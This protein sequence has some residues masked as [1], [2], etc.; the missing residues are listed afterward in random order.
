MA[1]C[2]HEESRLIS[3]EDRKRM[4][5]SFLKEEIYD[6]DHRTEVYVHEKSCFLLDEDLCRKTESTLNYTDYC[7]RQNRYIQKYDQVFRF[8]ITPDEKPAEVLLHFLNNDIEEMDLEDTSGVF[9]Q[10]HVD[11]TPLE[12]SFESLFQEAYGNDAV[13]YLQKEYAVSLEGGRNAFIDYVIETVH[14]NY[15]IEENGVHYHHPQL[16]GNN[17]YNEQLIKQDT[18]CL[19][20]F[21]VYRFSSE[22]VKFHDQTIDQIKKFLGPKEDFIEPHFLT[23]DRTVHLYEHQE[24]MLK[25]MQE[26]RKNGETTSLIVCPTGSGKSQIIL[27]DLEDLNKHHQ[28]HRVLIMVP[29]R[30]IKDDWMMR[31]QPLQSDLEI[32]VE[33][34]NAVFLQRNALPADYY[35]Y[36]A[37]DEAHHAQAANCRKT[38]QYFAPKYLIGMTAT[39]E[40]LDHKKLEEIFGHY[41]PQLSMQEAINKGV[42][43]NIRCFR[44]L[45]N[46]DLSNVRYNG[47]DYNY[48]DLERTLVVES[49]NELIVTT[50]KKY[51]SPRT[52]FYKQGIVF[53]VSQDHAKKLAKMMNAAGLKAAAVYGG[54]KQNDRNFDDYRNKRIQFLTS[55]QMISEGWDSPQTEVIVMARPTLSKVVYLQQLGRGVRRYPGKECLYCID[56]VDNYEGRLKPWNFNSLFHISE[57]SPFRG[58]IHNNHDY[59]SILGLHEEEIAMQEID[60]G[61][62]EEKYKGYLSPEQV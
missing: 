48:A 41:H 60:I 45:S 50:I 15:A 57:Y 59:L 39:D 61:T 26:A 38:L 62:F 2:D 58:L 36:I 47:K 23:A 29:T 49:R 1:E 14:G 21:K 53:C 24:R 35:D 44:L 37:F 30:K 8:N 42:I 54:N 55:C 12:K 18:L 17:R 46:I 25:E 5:L 19:Y 43:S 31:I 51:F 28:I 9:A 10:A 33:L 22:N 34:Y 3:E 7:E 52:D 6:K 56:V 27:S 40:R 16:I 11:N 4:H 20:G 32:H 13:K